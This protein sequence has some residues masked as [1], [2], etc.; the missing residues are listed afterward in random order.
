MKICVISGNRA[1]RAALTP[2]A[3]ALD[4]QWLFVETLP[5]RNRFDSA[6]GCGQAMM[7]AAEQLNNV[8]PDLVIL[9]GDRFEILGAACAAHLMST[10]IAHLSGGDVTEGSQDD[11]MRHAITKLAALHFPTTYEAADRLVA[12]GEEKWRIHMVGAP[13]IDYLLNKKLY[14]LHET[15]EQFGFKY[16]TITEDKYILVAYQP[17]TAV[18]DPAA[19]IDGLLKDLHETGMKCI[20]T[21]IN[22]DAGGLEITRKI[23][24]F[25]NAHPGHAM[26]KMDSKLFLSAMKHCQYMI[27]NSSAGFYEAPSLGT[28]FVNIGDRQKGRRAIRGDGKAAER[29]KVT[30]NAMML[31][32]RN[33][34]LQKKWGVECPSMLAGNESTV[35]VAGA[36]TPKRSWSA[37]YLD[38][39]VSLRDLG[40]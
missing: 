14:T 22:P 38:D 20:F 19:E 2:V 35:S 23:I 32:P 1:D 4:A 9:A 8:N 5:S 30:I 37:L 16:P 17:P 24:K 31:V 40:F 11:A 33:V 28:K 15:L 21:T 26:V 3:Q 27:G 39:P 29:I 7:A 34:L 13:Q 18:E 12:M 6:I 36:A 25:C 10:P